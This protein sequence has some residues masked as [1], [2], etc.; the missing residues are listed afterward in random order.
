MALVIKKTVDLSSIGD[1][2]KG[3]VLNFKPIPAKK[4]S[5]LQTKIDEVGDN[6]AAAIP[7]MVDILVDQFLDGKASESE[8]TKEDV[9]EFE[10]DVV[11]HCFRILTGQDIDPKSS[12]ELTTTSP[13]D[14][15]SAQK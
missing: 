14:G 6:K 13:M 12:A 9:A 1:E 11:G 5:D 10:A 3:V 8:V 7:V 2:Y 4:L 15:D